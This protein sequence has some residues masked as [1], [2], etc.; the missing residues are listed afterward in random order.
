[1]YNKKYTEIIVRRNNSMSLCKGSYLKF[2]RASKGYS[3][4]SMAGIMN[5][6]DD[7]YKTLEMSGNKNITLD[8]C[9]SLIKNLKINPLEIIFLFG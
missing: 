7:E 5:M 6:Q 9:D 2:L 8:N 3:I 1:M 4:H